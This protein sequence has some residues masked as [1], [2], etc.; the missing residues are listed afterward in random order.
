M[1]GYTN[2]T[3][4]KGRK[5]MKKTQREFFTIENIMLAAVAVAVGLLLVMLLAGWIGGC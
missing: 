5:T 1:N 4:Q 3:Q 2:N